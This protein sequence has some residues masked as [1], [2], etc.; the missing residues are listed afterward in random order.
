MDSLREKPNTITYSSLISACE[1]GG[2]LDRALEWFENMQKA[3]VEADLITFSALIAACERN[4]ELDT[5]LRLL[6]LAHQAGHLAPV[7][8][9]TRLIE[10][11]GRRQNSEQA[12]E[13]F[14]SMQMAGG[15]RKC[16]L[17]QPRFTE[18]GRSL[19]CLS[20]ALYLL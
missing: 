10:H 12:L 9:Y 20:V 6:D 13:L 16:A 14:L 7:E 3:G 2:R 17:Y 19:P 4:E 8:T 5:A 1:R 11:C 18:E 15:E